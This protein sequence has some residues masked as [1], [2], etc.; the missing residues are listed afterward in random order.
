MAFFFTSKTFDFDFDSQFDL[1]NSVFHHPVSS[2]RS[3][4]SL[5]QV[6]TIR[7]STSSCDFRWQKLNEI[8]NNRRMLRP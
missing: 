1:F 8:G 2:Y 5:L 4:L 3:F 7:K 6:K